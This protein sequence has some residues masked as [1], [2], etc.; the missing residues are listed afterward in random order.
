MARASNTP[1]TESDPLNW[2]AWTDAYRFEP[3]RSDRIWWAI[4]SDRRD[5]Q[6]RGVPAGLIPMDVAETLLF[7]HHADA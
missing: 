5:R 7:G 2:P 3:T 1:D 4:E 6:R